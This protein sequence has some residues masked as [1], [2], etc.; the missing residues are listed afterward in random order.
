MRFI[1]YSNEVQLL[2]EAATSAA[3][4]LKSAAMHKP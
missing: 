1:S 3:R 2:Q 4:Q